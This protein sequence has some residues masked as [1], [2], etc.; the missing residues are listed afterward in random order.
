MKKRKDGPNKGRE[1]GTEGRKK[2]RIDELTNNE[3]NKQMNKWDEGTKGGKEG[4][5]W[6]KKERKERMGR[7]NKL[8]N[9]RER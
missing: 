6:R 9:R 7:T 1:E 2:D 5:I 4:T 8:M 3:T